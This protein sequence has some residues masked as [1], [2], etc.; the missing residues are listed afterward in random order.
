MFRSEIIDREEANGV[1]GG[2]TC[3]E[4]V[5]VDVKPVKGNFNTAQFFNIVLTCGAVDH[6]HPTFKKPDEM[7]GNQQHTKR[8]PI[9]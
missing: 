5:M 7:T 4:I 6:S 8:K 9:I 2:S 1:T 3:L